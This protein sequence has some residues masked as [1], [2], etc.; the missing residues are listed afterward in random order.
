MATANELP[1]RHALHGAATRAEPAAHTA[2]MGGRRAELRRELA[3]RQRVAGGA[4][5]ALLPGDE[6]RQT[7]VVA[8]AGP[9]APV[10]G[11]KR[12]SE[13]DAHGYDPRP[14]GRASCWARGPSTPSGL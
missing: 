2:D 12:R 1:A 5:R 8:A 3:G 4:R 6:S 10:G 11:G 9:D 7:R 14:P 13:H